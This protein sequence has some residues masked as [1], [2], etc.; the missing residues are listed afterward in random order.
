MLA[1]ALTAK[2][3]ILIFDEPTQGIDVGAKAE[4][5]ELIHE[6]AE[7]GTAVIVISS[8]M[9]EAIG[10]SNRLL[11]MREGRVSGMLSA[12][13]MTS[14]NTIRLMYRSEES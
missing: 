8:E 5:Y 10:I 1:K 13:E 2:P 7:Q 14:E 6:M 11:V 12:E 9:E 4:I 3:K